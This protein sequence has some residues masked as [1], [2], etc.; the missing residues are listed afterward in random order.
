[1]SSFEAA[2]EEL[3]FLKFFL[4]QI[5]PHAQDQGVYIA[6]VSTIAYSLSLGIAPVRGSVYK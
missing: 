1:M 2:L 3:N 4:L 6:I 5:A